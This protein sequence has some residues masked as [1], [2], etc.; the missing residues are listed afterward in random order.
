MNLP[1]NKTP[2]CPA[3]VPVDYAKARRRRPS[4]FPV[5]GIGANIAASVS[6]KEA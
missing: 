5:T 6:G 2:Q 1:M 3:D 4:P